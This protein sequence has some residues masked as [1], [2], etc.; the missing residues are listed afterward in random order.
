MFSQ[1]L[2]ENKLI[3]LVFSQALN[4]FNKLTLNL[5]TESEIETSGIPSEL[6]KIARI[7]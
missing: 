7:N 5:A 4:F 3:V 6:H 2:V 1:A